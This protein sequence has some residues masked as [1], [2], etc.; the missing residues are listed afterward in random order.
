[1]EFLT[2]KNKAKDFIEGMNWRIEEKQKDINDCATLFNSEEPINFFKDTAKLALSIA[3]DI[4]YFQIVKKQAEI[5]I[6]KNKYTLEK[7]INTIEFYNA[8]L[9]KKISTSGWNDPLRTEIDRAELHAT[10]WWSLCLEK[11]FLEAFG[12]E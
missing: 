3:A 7:A 9:I 6:T 2:M 10:R 1:M 8:R 5:I 12:D 4:Q 11:E